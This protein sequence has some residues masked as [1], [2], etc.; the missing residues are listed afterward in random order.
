LVQSEK[1]ASLGILAAGVAHEINNPL[2]FIQ[3]GVYGIENIINQKLEEYKPEF[4]PFLKGIEEGVRRASTIVTSLN[5]YSRTDKSKTEVIDMHV[6]IDNC[7][8]MLHNQIKNNTRVEKKYLTSD[9]GLIG[10]E[11]QLH[12]LMLNVLSNSVQAIKENGLITIGTKIINQNLQISI[13]DNGDGI[14]EENL[15]KIFDPFF[16][17]KDP[18]QGTGLGMAVSLKIIEEHNGKIE[19]K[20]KVDEGTEVVI[21]LPVNELKKD[22]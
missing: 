15:S 6:I 10:N 1:M 21:S 14:S 18:G 17:T 3:G 2:N 5:H 7:L 13:K 9:Y 20:S 4:T 16:T 12:Q 19:Y 11:G 22:G 8:L